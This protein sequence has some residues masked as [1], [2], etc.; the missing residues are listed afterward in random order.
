MIFSLSTTVSHAYLMCWVTSYVHSIADCC[1]NS[2]IQDWI[3]ESI[4]LELF[5]SKHC[6]KRIISMFYVFLL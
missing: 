2:I 5:S 4:G 3:D 6:K 1:Q